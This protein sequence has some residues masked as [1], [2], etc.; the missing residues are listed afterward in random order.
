M[1][2]LQI[3][4]YRHAKSVLNE[5]PENIG[6]QPS[7]PL[8]ETGIEQANLLGKNLK[9]KGI[10]YDLIYSSNYVRALHT[11]KIVSG[12]LN[13]KTIKVSEALREYDPGNLTGQNRSKIY[14]DL[15]FVKNLSDLNMGYLFPNGDSLFQVERRI[16]EWIEEELLYNKDLDGKK[17]KIAIFSHGITIKCLLHYIMNFDR[18]FIWKI[19]IRNTSVSSFRYN[20]R[21]W[22][23]DKIGDVS[24]LE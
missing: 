4:V 10:D 7:T 11:A 19:N 22:I 24:H 2:N 9:D 16:S 14:S 17:L 23:V 5:N 18:S 20:E 6:Q 1:H 13:N 15:N 3:D 21:G 12:Y 8:S